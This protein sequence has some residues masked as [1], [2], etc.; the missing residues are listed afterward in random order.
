MDWINISWQGKNRASR[1]PYGLEQHQLARQK[2]GKPSAISR[3]GST[4]AGKAIT[5]H[6]A[7]H[8]VKQ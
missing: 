7:Y 8:R 2:Q 1:P 4:S 5:G 3:T 6:K